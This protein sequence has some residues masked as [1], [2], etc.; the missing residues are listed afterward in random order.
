MKK[1]TEELLQL[2]KKSDTLDHYIESASDD[3]I[4][5]SIGKEL[6]VLVNQSG[7]KPAEIFRRA[8]IEKSYGY[9]IIS[10][11]RTPS[12]SK[13]LCILFGLSYSLSD[14]QK[15]LKRTGYPPLYPKNIRDSV[16]MFCLERS[17]SLS[18]C[19]ETLYDMGL[20]L[21]E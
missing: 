2:L 1:S 5:T 8:S 18:D 11:K 13:V 17:I 3:L 16:I 4:E 9:D 14:T 7:K 10:G 21:L 12:R 19:N 20:E 15:L 6:S